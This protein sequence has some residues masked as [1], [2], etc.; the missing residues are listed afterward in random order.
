M[1]ASL[2]SWGGADLALDG[3]DSSG[4]TCTQYRQGRAAYHSSFTFWNIPLFCWAKGT[5]ERTERTPV[6]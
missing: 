3:Q 5:D 4:Q 6:V 2:L 1:A